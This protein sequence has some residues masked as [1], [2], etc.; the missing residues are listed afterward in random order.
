MNV[1]DIAR[2][3][4]AVKVVLS[5]PTCHFVMTSNTSSKLG[6]EWIE[7]QSFRVAIDSADKFRGRYYMDLPVQHTH[8][9][10][11]KLAAIARRETQLACFHTLRVRQEKPRSVPGN[12][13]VLF[14]MPIMWPT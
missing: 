13:M 9:V 4:L 12:L 14:P 1:S 8:S 5:Y 10:N 7:G 2:T 11:W 3:L 6:N